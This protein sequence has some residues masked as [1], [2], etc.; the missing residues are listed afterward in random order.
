M[1]KQRS[2][3]EQCDHV[4]KVANLKKEAAEIRIMLARIWEVKGSALMAIHNR[5]NALVHFLDIGL[6]DQAAIQHREI[7]RLHL[8]REERGNA[9]DSLRVVIK[10][11]TDSGIREEAAAKITEITTE[12]AEIQSE[13]GKKWADPWHAGHG[14]FSA[15]EGAKALPWDRK[16]RPGS[17]PVSP[18]R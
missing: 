3:A 5:T 12:E 11:S 2:I 1:G 8:E 14:H 9:A 18:C 4:A 17:D 15:H 16:N 13:L 7:A 6:P 10:L